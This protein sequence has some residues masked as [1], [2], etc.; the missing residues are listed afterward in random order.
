MFSGGNR[1]SFPIQKTHLAI[2]APESS[3]AFLFPSSKWDILSNCEKVIRAVKALTH[4]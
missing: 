3:K 1:E 2:T 4:G